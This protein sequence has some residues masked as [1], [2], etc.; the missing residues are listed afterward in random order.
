MRYQGQLVRWQDQQGF[1]FIQCLGTD[2][3]VFVHISSFMSASRRPLV[4]DRL[5]FELQRDRQGRWQ[6]VQVQWLDVPQADVVRPTVPAL[7]WMTLLVF[8]AGLVLAV[9]SERLVSG[10]PLCYLLMS[11]LTFC[12]YGMDKR[13]AR[14]GRWRVAEQ[15]LHAL[16]LLGGW[17]GA[18]L[19][20]QVFR[21]KTRKLAFRWLFGVT[22]ALNL[23][24]LWLLVRSDLLRPVLAVH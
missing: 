18:L 9:W 23:A 24:G 14:Q 12:C 21:H 15:T 16:A 17:P 1:G 13:A 8:F 7:V 4:A 5:S 3:Q 2:R 11:A 20:Q 10:V 19:G 6:A 22:V